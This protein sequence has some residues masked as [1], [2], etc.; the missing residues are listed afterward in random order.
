MSQA[1]HNLHQAN[2]AFAHGDITGAERL[3]D[4]AWAHVDHQHLIHMHSDLNHYGG[5]LQHSNGFAHHPDIY[6]RDAYAD[7][8]RSYYDA[9]YLM[10]IGDPHAYDVFQ[11]SQAALADA[12]AQAHA[13]AMLY[14]AAHH[15]PVYLGHPDIVNAWTPYA[16]GYSDVLHT[17]AAGE[18]GLDQF[19]YQ[20]VF[21]DNA[22]SLLAANLPPLDH[23]SQLQ[24]IEAIRQTAVQH[25]DM[26]H[27]L[28]SN[29]QIHGH[30]IVVHSG[31]VWHIGAAFEDP[32]FRSLLTHTI[33]TH[34]HHLAGA[35]QAEGS[36]HGYMNVIGGAYASLHPGRIV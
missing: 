15:P 10:Q 30:D 12:Q 29:A 11:Y 16:G 31:S 26:L 32:H 23:T 25:P 24:L 22:H 20:N 36:V 14:S 4:N 9:Q 2:A 3:L 33:N 7:A 19:F 27:L 8:M 1:M 5:L 35:L 17:V 13:D 6:V 18:R 28:V 21:N 34:Y